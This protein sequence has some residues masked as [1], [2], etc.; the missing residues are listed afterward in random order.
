MKKS[1]LLLLS[2]LFFFNLSTARAT[3]PPNSVINNTIQQETP[4]NNLNYNLIMEFGPY[5]GNSIG[6][7]GIA[8]NGISFK[9]INLLGIGVGFEWDIHEE[10]C[11][12]LY[13]NFRHYFP[14][15]NK[16]TPLVNIGLGTRLLIE[17]YYDYDVDTN[18]E[19]YKS[20]YNGCGLYTTI[21]AGF[22]AGAFSFNSGFFIKTGSVGLTGGIDVRCGFT[23]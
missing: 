22:K 1:I 20:Q 13:V 23:F 12:P 15:K 17:S 14:K 10:Y 9:N 6:F 7:S 11:I 16:I 3:T 19:I 8:V 2:V 5:L 18:E 21:S 4:A